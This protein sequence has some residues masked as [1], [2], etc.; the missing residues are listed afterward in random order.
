MRAVANAVNSKEVEEN[1]ANKI[2]T[3]T[4]LVKDYQTELGV[5]ADGDWGKATEAAWDSTVEREGY[6][7]YPTETAD[8]MRDFIEKSQFSQTAPQAMPQAP[9]AMPQ[10]PQAEYFSMEDLLM[11]R[12]LLGGGRL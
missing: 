9:Q 7:A 5:K 10:A 4:D 2:A 11:D 12:N 1:K 3:Y 6:K 8:P